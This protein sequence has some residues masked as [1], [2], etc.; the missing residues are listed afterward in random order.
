MAPGCNP[1]EEHLVP[2]E[3][4]RTSLPRPSV[5]SLEQAPQRSHPPLVSGLGEVLWRFVGDGEL[6][7]L[8][9]ERLDVD[10]RG[11]VHERSL[12]VF[13]LESL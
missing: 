5:G 4:A 13:G 2:A 7:P 11:R 3:L 9:D 8:A 12:R 10:N 6:A 1:T